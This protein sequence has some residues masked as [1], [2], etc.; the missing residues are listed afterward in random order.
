MSQAIMVPITGQGTI[1]D[2][3]IGS[4]VPALAQPPFDF[5]DVFVYS[6]GWWTTANDAMVDYTRF[7]VGFA[8]TLLK[9]AAAFG[10]PGAT[11]PRF[12]RSALEVGIHWPSMV[13]ED[14]SSILNIAQPL[15]F[16]KRANMADDVGEHGGYALVRMILEGRQAA[17][18]P[19]PRF[20]LIGHSF[21]CKVVHARG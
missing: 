1:S 2:L 15:S 17:G 7:T 16:Y 12:P 9:A 10:P 4:T 11:A 13:S 8:T 20:H 6:H 19:Q 5:S 14:A 3:N 21:G 18:L